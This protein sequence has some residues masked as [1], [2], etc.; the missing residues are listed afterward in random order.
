MS[1]LKITCILL[2]SRYIC[3][4]FGVQARRLNDGSVVERIVGREDVGEPMP[5]VFLYLEQLYDAI[6]AEHGRVG[7]KGRDIVHRQCQTLYRN[8]TQEA[9]ELFRLCC[10]VCI[11]KTGKIGFTRIS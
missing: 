2:L 4:T 7:H 11:A 3:S 5:R 6:E 10:H 9:V 1:I 8:V